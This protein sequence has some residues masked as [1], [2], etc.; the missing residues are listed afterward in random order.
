MSTTFDLP[1][2]PNSLE[3]QGLKCP[4]S[5]P[6]I[7]RETDDAFVLRC[8]TCQ[9]INVWPKPK[10]EDRGR[11]QAGMM[12][13]SRRQKEEDETRRKRAYSFGGK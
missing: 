6:R 4:R 11:Y 12:A 9:G 13:E 8:Q 2:C 5:N 7:E 3:T 10:A 1:P